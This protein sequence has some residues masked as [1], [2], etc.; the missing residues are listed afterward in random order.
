MSTSTTGDV[1]AAQRILADA[2]TR[3]D[4]L[5]EELTASIDDVVAK[6]RPDPESNS[7]AWLVW[8]SARV[9][10]DH[11]SELAGKPQL[12]DTW[13][14]KFDLP[15]GPEATGYGQRPAD[16]RKVHPDL[17]KLY[18]YFHA[19]YERVIEY[20]ESLTP[21]ELDRVVDR[22]WDPPVTASSRLVSVLG[23]V[24][25]HLGQASY[26]KGLAERADAD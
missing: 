9:M 6:Y 20:I 12:W 7:I 10:D 1:R 4:D 14:E 17:D 15:F 18:A 25:Q 23:D 13:R 8:H 2:F 22:R 19:V 16:V 24:T 26:V 3:M 21:E 11:V 5:A